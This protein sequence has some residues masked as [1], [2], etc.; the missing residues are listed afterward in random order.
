MLEGF[1]SPSPDIIRISVLL[2][3]LID[4]GIF[5]LPQSNISFRVIESS[6]HRFRIVVIVECLVIH[7]PVMS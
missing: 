1:S 2:R 6:V 5:V 3:L 7:A 4:P